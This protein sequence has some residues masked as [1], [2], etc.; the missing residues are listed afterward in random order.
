MA[1]LVKAR[2]GGCRFPGCSTALRF[3]DLDHVIAWP[4]GATVT[5]NLIALCRRHHRIKQTHGWTVHLDPDGT[6]TWTDPT[7][8][9]RT[10]H[11]QRLLALDLTTVTAV[12]VNPDEVGADHRIAT[13]L[14]GCWSELE[15]AFELVLAV[16]RRGRPRVEVNHASARVMVSPR[17]LG[18]PPP[19]T[20]RP[21]PGPSDPPPF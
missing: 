17:R 1:A 15:E 4:T 2:D 6:T 13:G 19:R 7:G 20:R 10:T 16:E 18:H 12:R 5:S 21:W 11:P 14:T 8:R 3:C 9:I